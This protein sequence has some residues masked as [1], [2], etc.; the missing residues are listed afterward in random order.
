MTYRLHDKSQTVQF[1]QPRVL[2]GRAGD[3]D[4]MLGAPDVSRKHAAIQRDQEGWTIADLGS[5]HGTFVNR[6]RVASRRLEDGD[7]ITLGLG[8]DPGS[9]LR[10]HV[11]PPPEEGGILFDD[12][13]TKSNIHL[14]INVEDFERAI[15]RPRE[16]A[17]AGEPGGADRLDGPAARQAKPP[18]PETLLDAIAGQSPL[19]RPRVSI[20]GLFKQVGE[21]LLQ[22]DDLE[23]MLARVVDLALKNLPAER[24]FICLCDEATE[25]ITPKVAR[26]KGVARGESINISRSIAREAIR[27][28]QALMV[29]DA[30]TDSRFAHSQSIRFEGIRAAMCAPLYHAGRVEGL[31]YVDSLGCDRFTAPDLELLT[32]LGVLTAVGI[33]QARLRDDVTRERAIR[34]RLAR[35]SSPHVVEQIVAGAGGL[36]DEMVAQ[37][38]EVT[39]L[40][41]DLSRFTPMVEGAEPTQVARVLNSAFEQLTQAVFLY[42]GTLDKYLGDGLLAIFGAPLSQSD[43]AERAI[44][45]ALLMQQVLDEGGVTGPNGERLEMRIGIN[46]GTA[47]AGDI[48]SATRKDYTVVGDAINVASR[49]ESSVAKPGQIVIG[50]ATYEQCGEAFDLRPLPEIRLKGK[51]R[52]I[53]PYLVFGQKEGT[54]STPERPT[55][56]EP[57]PGIR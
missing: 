12:R 26:V 19:D 25:A 2:I 15:D 16:T 55:S 10:F 41:A 11:P 52:A 57:R 40:F 45:A 50:P 34:A 42:D 1:S 53:Q 32:A 48:G 24:G 4:L 46:S 3:C 6:R 20:I 39:V 30:L 36:E 31:I 37:E 38:R 29:S 18:G 28:R 43:H 33:V 14:T 35:Y 23:D 5:R 22:S 7:Q 27:A 49:L 56:A 13:A 17:G 9:I 47:V 44:R 51:Q 54:P 8:T 21:V